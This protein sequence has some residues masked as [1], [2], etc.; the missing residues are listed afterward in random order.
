MT[1]PIA[2]EPHWDP[3]A[4]AVDNGALLWILWAQKRGLPFIL[5]DGTVNPGSSP[6]SGNWVNIPLDQVPPEWGKTYPGQE[7]P[8]KWVC[9]NTSEPGA[10][11]YQ[12]AD[13]YGR[14]G[15]DLWVLGAEAQ[16]ALDASNAIL[17]K[18]LPSEILPAP[19]PT[20]PPPPPPPPPGFW[21][22]LTRLRA[23][24]DAFF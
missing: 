12:Y 22:Y 13:L 17:M 23:H 6:C 21:E 14:A 9:S 10:L 24:F 4:P 1:F 20:P 16:S 8:Q 7:A 11:I 3:T 15:F 18:T 19:R 2:V 5:N